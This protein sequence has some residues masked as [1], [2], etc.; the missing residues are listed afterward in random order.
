MIVVDASCLFEVLTSHPRADPISARLALEEGHAAPH[1]VDVE[2]YGVIR[3]EFFR[4]ALDRTAARQAV[5][6]LAAWPGERYPHHLFLT[7]AWALRDSVSG[8]DSMYV[9]LAETL[10][11]TL[12]TADARLAAAR[13]PRCPIELAPEA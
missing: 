13:G 2:V 3:R 11:A 10:G 5:E 4:G 9:A 8:P 12:L 7:R 1:L 6:R